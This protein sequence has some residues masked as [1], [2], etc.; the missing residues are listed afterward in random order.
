MANLEIHYLGEKKIQVLLKEGRAVMD[1][2]DFEFDKNVDTLLLESVD[3]ILK[4]NKIDI[5][6]LKNV[7]LVGDIDKNSSLYKIVKSFE[8]AVDNLKD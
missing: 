5:T 6:S 8:S 3:K 2:V 4:R 7:R 1:T